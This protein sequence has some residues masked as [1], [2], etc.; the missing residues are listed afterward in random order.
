MIGALY[1]LKRS[2]VHFYDI[3]CDHTL[4]VIGTSGTLTVVWVVMAESTE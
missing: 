3:S 2:A 4:H 1:K